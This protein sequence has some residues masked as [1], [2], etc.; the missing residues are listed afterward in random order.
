MNRVNRCICK[1]SST[2][3]TLAYTQLYTLVHMKE[4][5]KR[6]RR[7]RSSDCG[8]A[9]QCHTARVQFVNTVHA[10]TYIQYTTTYWLTPTVLVVAR[11]PLKNAAL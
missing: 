6:E 4:C 3:Y 11:S 9:P 8:E 2:V 7:Q 5:E 1:A 10:D